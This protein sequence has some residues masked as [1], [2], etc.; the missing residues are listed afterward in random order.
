MEKFKSVSLNL[1]ILFLNECQN[2][3]VTF[4]SIL[5]LVNLMSATRSMVRSGLQ[6]TGHAQVEN[7]DGDEAGRLLQRLLLL[8]RRQAIARRCRCPAQPGGH[9][10]GHLHHLRHPQRV[11]S[12]GNSRKNEFKR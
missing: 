11:K 2:V 12:E 7:Q 1:W 9:V 4:I 5:R 3:H 10:A 6:E 8:L